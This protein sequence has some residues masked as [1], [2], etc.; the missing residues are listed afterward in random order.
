MCILRL[1]VVWP[2]NLSAWNNPRDRIYAKALMIVERLNPSLSNPFLP[3]RQPF[4][5]AY[6]PTIYSARAVYVHF[7]YIGRVCINIHSIW[8]W[9]YMMRAIARAFNKQCVSVSDTS[10]AWSTYMPSAQFGKINKFP[11]DVFIVK[12]KRTHKH[13]NEVWLGES[14]SVGKLEYIWRIC[15]YLFLYVF[16]FSDIPTYIFIG[17]A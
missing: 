15:I 6:F 14:D 7:A 17:S 13:M 10:G 8:F 4:P 16:W 9:L 1:Y 12:T 11:Q 2:T 5:R 3:R